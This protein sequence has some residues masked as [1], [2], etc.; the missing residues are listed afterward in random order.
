MDDE[1]E[2]ARMSNDELLAQNV[3]QQAAIYAL[4]RLLA[5]GCTT[6]NA[7]R[8]R[9]GARRNSLAIRE[10]ATRRAGIDSLL[11]TEEDMGANGQ[12]NGPR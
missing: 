6:A 11:S 10:E 4:S 7:E 9:E 2:I 5:M 8:L 12:G 1:T 3:A